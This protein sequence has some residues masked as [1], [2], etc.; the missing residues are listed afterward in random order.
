MSGCNSCLV[1][2]MAIKWCRKLEV[3]QKRCPVVFQGHLSNFKVTRDKKLPIFTRI[4]CFRTV[5]S[6]LIHQWLWNDVQSLKS[7]EEVPYFLLR[8]FVKFQGHARQK[9][10]TLTQIG[11]FR[12]VTPVW[13]HWWLWQKCTKPNMIWKRCPIVFRSHPSNFKVTRAEKSTIQIQ[14]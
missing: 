5:T 11:H 3:A 4:E 14:Y 7:R 6:V 13:I 8:L 12:T 1:L 10:P 9:L 2:Q